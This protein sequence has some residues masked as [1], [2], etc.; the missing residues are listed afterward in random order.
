MFEGFARKR[1][2]V[3]DVTINCVVAG[4]GPALLLLHGYPQNLAM[5]AQVAPRLAE[6]FT[7]VCSDLRG[8]GD[9]SK[10]RCSAD[11]SNYSFRTMAAD[12]VGM[13]AN[14]GFGRFH[15]VGHDRGAR[16]AHRMALDHPTVVETLSVLDIA[17][18]YV[19]FMQTDRHVA[20]A[21][22]HWFFLALPEP[23]PERLI[24][25]DPDFF[26]EFCLI[27][28]GKTP[29]GDF[30]RE[31]LDDYR[32]CW[33]DPAMIHGSCADYRAAAT[34]DLEHDA[35]DLAR[36]VTCPTLALWGSSGLMHAHFDLA[37]AWEARASNLT[38]ATLPGGHFFIDQFPD[39]TSRMLLD[40]L[41]A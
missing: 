30:N 33:R 41:G 16:T 37:T 15:V 32:R 6:R 14:L 22:W 31:M 10:P 3:E 36:K 11:R 38:T 12:Q 29:L 20:A 19:M 7:V 21:Y 27:N 40:F 34:V 23:V 17:P 39:E 28:W 8:Y 9:S 4:S 24:G 5:W 35:A 26:F 18:T 1:I 13:M 2:V 25:S